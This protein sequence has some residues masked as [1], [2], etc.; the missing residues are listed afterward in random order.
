M[1][2]QKYIERA[3]KNVEEKSFDDKYDYM[4]NP[5]Y[6]KDE[7]EAYNLSNRKMYKDMAE[8]QE[9]KQSINNKKLGKYP[10][11]RDTGNGDQAQLKSLRQEIQNIRETLKE[12]QE[13]LSNYKCP[14]AI[15]N[16]LDKIPEPDVIVKEIKEPAL[17]EQRTAE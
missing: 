3:K 6:E 15:N 12:T 1:Y 5:Y 17:P 10:K 7:L 13:K 11:I 2:N 4:Q 9:T 8:M 14:S 16:S